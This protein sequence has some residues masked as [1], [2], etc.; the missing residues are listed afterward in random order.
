MRA[1]PAVEREARALRAVGAL[2]VRAQPRGVAAAVARA[3]ARAAHRPDRRRAQPA[4]LP[5]WPRHIN[6]R[7][8]RSWARTNGW[9]RRSES[10]ARVTKHCH[11]CAPTAPTRAVTAKNKRQRVAFGLVPSSHD[12]RRRAAGTARRVS[13]PPVWAYLGLSGPWAYL[14]LS[15]RI[16]AYLGLSGPIS[17]LCDAHGP[18]TS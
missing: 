15:E 8:E 5:H 10:L 7:R 3:R 13:S 2:A 12:H 6:R 1:E 11:N 17:R 18:E 14:G 16:W 9:R 4:A